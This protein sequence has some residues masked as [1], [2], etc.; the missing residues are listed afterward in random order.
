MW[1]LI[2]RAIAQ[3]TGQELGHVERRSVGGGC[4]NQAYRLQDSAGHLFFVKLNR[5]ERLGMFEAEALGLK[6]MRQAGAIAIPKPLCWGVAEKSSY[7]VLEW[8]D[9]GGRGT[10]AWEAMGRSLATMHRWRSEDQQASPR[11]GWDRDNTIGATHQPNGWME[12][13]VD[14]FRDRRLGFQ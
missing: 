4:I 12:S 2:T 3:G 5:A 6:A 7:I 9:L 11:F 8:M 14:F 1:D 10:E 13:W